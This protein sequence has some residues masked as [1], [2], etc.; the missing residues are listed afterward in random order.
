MYLPA[1][2]WYLTL[3]FSMRFW[4]NPCA[5][6]HSKTA[7]RSSGGSPSTASA[8][9]FKLKLGACGSTR[10]R[11]QRES[12]M[13]SLGS[14]TPMCTSLRSASDLARLCPRMLLHFLASLSASYATLFGST[15]NLTSFFP[16]SLYVPFSLACPHAQYVMGT[17]GSDHAN[18]TGLGG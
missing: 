7:S 17:P 11:L 18:P 3:P 9:G 5:C 13:R 8:L 6:S 1:S 14:L 16:R 15:S 12:S 2:F 4:M 10:N